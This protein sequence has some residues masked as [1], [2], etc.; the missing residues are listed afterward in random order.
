MITNAVVESTGPREMRIPAFVPMLLTEL[1]T[2]LR[3]QLGSEP[4]VR[5]QEFNPNRFTISSGDRGVKIQ[6]GKWITK[7]T[8][9]L[10]MATKGIEHSMAMNA[11]LVAALRKMDN[12]LRIA[13][14]FSNPIAKSYS[15]TIPQSWSEQVDV[16]VAAD[17]ALIFK[18]N[19]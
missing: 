10:Q 9:N 11:G 14:L 3:G 6:L 7:D 1:K 18:N 19:N 8:W 13:R 12:G 2:A 16:H 17:G 5:M 15:G 4:D